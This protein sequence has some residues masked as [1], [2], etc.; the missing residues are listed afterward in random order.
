MLPRFAV[1]A[2]LQ[3]LFGDADISPSVA[4]GAAPSTDTTEPGSADRTEPAPPPV[5]E[6][7]V[8]LSPE[9]RAALAAQNQARHDWYARN[10]EPER[11]IKRG[12]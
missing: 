9:R 12:G 3:Q 7:G 10:G 5:R 8:E 2:H 6:L 4:D 11:S 1:E